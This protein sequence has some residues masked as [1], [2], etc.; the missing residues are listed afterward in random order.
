MRKKGGIIRTVSVLIISVFMLTLFSLRG[1][2][3]KEGTKEEFPLIS[4]SGEKYDEVFE[5]NN[6]SS[7]QKKETEQ[8]SSS[9]KSEASKPVSASGNAKGK[10]INR[11]ISPYSAGLSYNNVY[12]KNS[13]GL[14]IDIKSLLDSKLAFNIQKNSSPQVLIV[15]T[16]TT[17]S[18][19]LEDR[20]Y[21]TSSD[22]SRRTDESKNMVK[23]GSIV[24]KKLNSAGIKTLHVKTKHDYPNYNGSYSRAADTICSYLKKY[25]SIK[26]VIDMHRD[27]VTSGASDK[28]KLTTDI[29]GKKAAQI[30]LVMGSQSGTVKNFPKWK[31]NLK[32]AVKMQ[33]TFEVMYPKLARPLSLTSKNYNESLTTGSVLLE[34]G[35]DANTLDEAM[36]S[37]E[38]VG[39]ALVSLFNTLK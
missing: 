24:A 8:S 33:Q 22:L 20:D 10:I 28:I 23:L 4:A 7:T 39:N 3:F 27:A 2:F 25:P 18:F 19:M 35:T 37:A 9:T 34:M 1:I 38:L 14:N 21:Y 31:E 17:E 12:I 11:Y 16:H 6:S 30:M 32:L 13:T 5:S 36:Y 29:N 15:H 26:I